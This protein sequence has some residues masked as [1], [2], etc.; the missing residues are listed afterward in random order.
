MTEDPTFRSN[1]TPPETLAETAADAVAHP[2]QPPMD[3]VAEIEA[4]DKAARLGD[5]A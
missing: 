3:N 1:A 4:E 5:F 2:E